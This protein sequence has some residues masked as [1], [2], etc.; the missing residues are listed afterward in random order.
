MKSILT[1]DVFMR[2]FYFYW[3]LVLSATVVLITCAHT[4]EAKA[5][6]VLY[7]IFP[8]TSKIEKRSHQVFAVD[9]NSLPFELAIKKVKGN[10][11][12]RMAYFTDP[13]CGYC[14]KLEGELKKIDNATLYLFLYP[15]FP[16]SDEK[17]K[18]VWCSRDKTAAW[19]DLMLNN[20]Q[21]PVGTCDTPLVKVLKLGE[22]LNV[23]ATPVL[24][25][26]DGVIVTGFLTAPD[27]EKALDGNSGFFG[28]TP[29]K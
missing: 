20:M 3:L 8:Q 28:S 25:F 7:K 2:I 23:N 6:G 12:R 9:F 13:N 22:K 15:I 16:G 5:E 27:M 4:S 14:K 26:S 10:G 29:L 1:R 11:Q 18:S 21:L 17:V 19:D 24:I